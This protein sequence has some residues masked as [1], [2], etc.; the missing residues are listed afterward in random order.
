MDNLRARDNGP[1]DHIGQTHLPLSFGL[2]DAAQFVI[3]HNLSLE[4]SNRVAD[5]VHT[6]ASKVL[7]TPLFTAIEWSSSGFQPAKVLYLAGR[8]LEEKTSRFSLTVAQAIA[9]IPTME[10][11]E[12]AAKRRARLAEE[13]ITFFDI[14]TLDGQEPTS[15][16]HSPASARATYLS[17]VAARPLCERRGIRRGVV[18]M[19][20]DS[21]ILMVSR[22]WGNPI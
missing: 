21:G 11:L 17:D 4:A 16:Y 9:N 19:V 8:I 3:G 5:V 20:N 14:H 2:A 6:L 22:A 15:S 18:R 13:A 1:A 12:E 10:D 7:H